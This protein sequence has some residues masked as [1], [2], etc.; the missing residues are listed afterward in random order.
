[1]PL[2]KI[3]SNY[4][5]SLGATLVAA[6]LFCGGKYFGTESRKYLSPEVARANQLTTYLI[7]A[8]RDVGENHANVSSAAAEL[9]QILSDDKVNRSFKKY[10]GY[11]TASL[12]CYLTGMACV[13]ASLAFLAGTRKLSKNTPIPELT[14][15]VRF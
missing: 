2:G 13:A 11:Q 7:S 8:S 12:D 1:M 4:K 6:T 15:E 3:I 5:W 10:E 9:T 14:R